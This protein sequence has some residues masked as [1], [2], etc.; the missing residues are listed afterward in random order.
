MRSHG[1]IMPTTLL[2]TCSTCRTNGKHHYAG[3][4]M[5]TTLLNTCSTCRTNGKHHYAGPIMLTTLLSTCSTCITNG[6]HHYAQFGVPWAPFRLLECAQMDPLCSQHCC[7]H[8]L[9][10]EQMANTTM[11]KLGL[12]GHHSDC[13]DALKWAHYAHNAAKHM[14]YM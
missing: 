14:F 12:L 4:I 5:L 6:K 1:P 3:P 2:N 10:V 9:H 7:S 11:L 8:V 13:L